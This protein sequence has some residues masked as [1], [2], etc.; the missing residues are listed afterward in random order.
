MPKRHVSFYLFT[1]I[2]EKLF[3]F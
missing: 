3:T 2:M 1:F